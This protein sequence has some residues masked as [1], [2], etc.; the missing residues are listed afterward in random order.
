MGCKR[1]VELSRRCEHQRLA[2]Q[3][4]FAIYQAHTFQRHAAAG[5]VDLGH[6]DGGVHHIAGTNRGEEFQRKLYCYKQIPALQQILL[7]EQDWM[8]V[9]SYT[10]TDRP[11]QWLNTDYVQPDETV[12]VGD[13]RLPMTDVYRNVVF[14][15]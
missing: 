9:S 7:I 2:L 13:L 5:V 12:A 14:S 11:N 3:D 1:S 15:E 8:L 6:R 4:R 10:R